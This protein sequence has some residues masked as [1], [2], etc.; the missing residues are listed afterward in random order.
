VLSH[1]IE[2]LDNFRKL[3]NFLVANKDNSRADYM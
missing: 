1:P 3:S 2:Y